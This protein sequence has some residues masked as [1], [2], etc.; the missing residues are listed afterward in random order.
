M[1]KIDL[2]LF[3]QLGSQLHPL[4]EFNLQASTRVDLI[5][6][7]LSVK[8]TTLFV[9]NSFSALTVCRA[10]GEKFLS[11]I[12]NAYKWLRDTPSEKWKEPDSSADTTF[13][14][15]I[16]KAKDF[17]TIL[18]ADLGT[19]VTYHATQKGIYDT[20]ALV[21]RAENI[22]PVPMLNRINEEVVT[23][24]RES[25]K[26]LAFDCATASGFHIMRATEMVMHKYYIY[27]FNPESDKRLHDWGKYIAK[28]ETVED[29]AVKE[30]VVM[31][32]QIKDQ[33][34]NLIMHPEIILS[35]NEAFTLFEIAKAAIITMADQ[36]PEGKEKADT[37]K[38]D[39]GK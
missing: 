15:I 28:F 2:P 19:L 7:G 29:S 30:V 11:A 12:D 14:Q 6:E 34:R 31:L 17:E 23:E 25:G 24:I 5:I 37:G 13:R 35:P 32:R 27:I 16:T 4:T 26:C 3:Y 18:T 39:E 33:H 1:E 21:G 20:A 22:L 36:L 10:A 8:T 9:L 38:S